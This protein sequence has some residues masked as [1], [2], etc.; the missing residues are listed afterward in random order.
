MKIT[1]HHFEN[2]QNPPAK[3]G[4]WEVPNCFGCDMDFCSLGQTIV[5]AGRRWKIISTISPLKVRSDPWGRAIGV[6]P[7]SEEL[8]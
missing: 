1:F 8:K 2:A 7:L 3:V 6:W 4:E 5:V